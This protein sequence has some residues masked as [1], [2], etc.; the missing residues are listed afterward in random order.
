MT[1][2]FNPNSP[3]NKAQVS[4][5]IFLSCSGKFTRHYSIHNLQGSNNLATPIFGGAPTSDFQPYPIVI[6]LKLS[7]CL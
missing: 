3:T 4:L 2:D 5:I 1:L 7:L 6:K